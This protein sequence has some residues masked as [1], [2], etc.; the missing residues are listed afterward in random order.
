M[1]TRKIITKEVAKMYRKA[2]KKKRGKILDEFCALNKYNR[3]YG[4]RLLRKGHSRGNRSSPKSAKAPP[5]EEKR[6]RG[7]IYGPEVARPLAR[8]WAILDCPCGKRLAA[9]LPETVRVLEKFGEI[10]LSSE[11]REKLLS[12]SASTTDRLLAPERKKLELKCRSKTR[13]GS[14]LK[15]QVPIRTFADWNEE[16]AGFVEMDLVGHD[17]GNAHGDYCQSLDAT[18]IETGWNE[19][20]AVKNKAQKWTFA[21]IEKI[22]ERFPFPLLGLDSDNGGEF[23]N[24]HLIRYCE[25]EKITFTRSRAYKKNDNCYVE[26]KN[27]TSVRRN[28]G[29]MR[30]DTEE[31]LALLN[32][33]YDV[34]RLY[35]NF[36]L[37]QMKLI[38]KTREGSKVKKVYDKPKT[39]FQR[40]LESPCVD[41]LVKKK[42]KRRYS[43]LNPAELKRQILNLQDQLYKRAV[44]KG[45]KTALEAKQEEHDLEYLFQ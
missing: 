5:G 39:P 23:I 16:R 34:L 45:E 17:G 4:A 35:N 44:F 24:D 18:D 2:S 20:R 30:Y 37:P 40:V 9:A 43:R 36:F 3:S 1:G 15:R 13:P 7:K 31:E 8:I 6:G 27:Y 42:L 19:Q 22:R 41:D 21:A 38:E 11:I 12:I 25:K 29:Y 10:K 26:Q 28:V 14:L 33:L 32:E